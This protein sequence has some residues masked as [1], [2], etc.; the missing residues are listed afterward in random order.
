MH[1]EILG[2]PKCASTSFRF[3][4]HDLY[5]KDHV[6][7]S[8]E[9]PYLPN[10]DKILEQK[11][12]KDPDLKFYAI[13][14]DPYE[15]L[16]SA[17]HWTIRWKQDFPEL[18]P[19]KA[20]LKYCSDDEFMTRRGLDKPAEKSDYNRFLEPLEKNYKIEVIKCEDL[21][22]SPKFPHEAKTT[23]VIRAIR[24]FNIDKPP[25]PANI[26]RLMKKEFKK[27]GMSERFYHWSHE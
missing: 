13:I 11:L 15:R 17:Y 5:G 1:Y 7:F 22:N 26:K 2:F 12:K 4:M 3:Y 25:I 9:T 24:G 8:K 14:R 23:T 10:Y 6:S 18:I 20:F 16:W 19:F 27:I 21:Y